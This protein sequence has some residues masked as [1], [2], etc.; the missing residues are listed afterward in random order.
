MDHCKPPPGPLNAILI[1]KAPAPEV[2]LIVF[3]LDHLQGVFYMFFIGIVISGAS[4]AAELYNA[5]KVADD[6]D[7]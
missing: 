3:S 6:D 5:W 2:N 1:L 4:L 7:F